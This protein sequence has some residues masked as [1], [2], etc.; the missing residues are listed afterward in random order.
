[1][2]SPGPTRTKVTCP[3]AP[4]SRVRDLNVGCQLEKLMRRQEASFPPSKSTSARTNDLPVCVNDSAASECPCQNDPSRGIRNEFPRAFS[5]PPG[6]RT[7]IRSTGR[8]DSVSL[9]LLDS[10]ASG[11]AARIDRLPLR[12]S[13]L[14]FEMHWLR[15][16]RRVCNWK[17]S[18]SFDLKRDCKKHCPDQIASGVT[19]AVHS[20][21]EYAPWANIDPDLWWR[22]NGPSSL[23]QRIP[24]W[25]ILS[26]GI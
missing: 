20:S 10:R 11:P 4:T 19:G 9:N 3:V 8:S 1:V 15:S 13:C 23:S 6:R 25:Q 17:Y 18:P 14:P 16:L 12:K 21:I 26:A 24:A 5:G 7:N 22:E 2:W